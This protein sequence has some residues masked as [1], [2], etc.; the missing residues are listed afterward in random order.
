MDGSIFANVFAPG[1]VTYLYGYGVFPAP[2]SGPP[3][4]FCTIAAGEGGPAQGA[5][6]LVVFSDYNNVDHGV[7][8]IIESNVFQEQTIDAGDV[9]GP[10]TSPS[11]R[12][13]RPGRQLYRAGLHQD[14]GSER[15]LQH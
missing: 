6:Q 9:G 3:F 12:S 2:N 1:G 14:P 4:A 15:W 11:R 13:W 8:N 7:G 5:Q 10:G